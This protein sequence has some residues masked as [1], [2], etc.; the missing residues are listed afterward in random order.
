MLKVKRGRRGHASSRIALSLFY[1]LVVENWNIVIC[2]LLNILLTIFLTYFVN[3]VG[4]QMF[5][6]RGGGGGKLKM[7]T[8]V[9]VENWKTW[10]GV[11]PVSMVCI[12][13]HQKCKNES[14]YPTGLPIL[15]CSK[16]QQNMQNLTRLLSL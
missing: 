7:E 4:K 1:A 15:T 14:T 6:G 9:L 2:E 10:R 3:I 5:W 11:V 8:A 13:R 16:H 12:W